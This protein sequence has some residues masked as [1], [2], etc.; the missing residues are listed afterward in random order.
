MT[1][2]NRTFVE[3]L[4]VAGQE[5]VGRVK[6][7]VQD[8]TTRR[9]TI[10]AQDGDE[11]MSMPLTFGVVAGGLVTLSAPALAGLGALAALVTRVRLEVTRDG[12]RAGPPTETATQ[13][14]AVTPKTDASA[15]F[16]TQT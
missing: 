9:V 10:Y 15:D 13:T 8:S 4:E 1:A 16:R 11:L 3:E 12:V 7:L 5:L 14:P 2:E 6:E